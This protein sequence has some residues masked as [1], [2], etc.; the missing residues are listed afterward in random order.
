MSSCARSCTGICEG[1]VSVSQGL[2][3]NVIYQKRGG[4]KN[5]FCYSVRDETQ[6]KHL[7]FNRMENEAL[8]QACWKLY[9]GLSH[10]KTSR[11]ISIR[12]AMVTGGMGEELS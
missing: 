12:I 1:G 11:T 10:H 3:M 4:K 7:H 8:E 9:G 2:Q 5:T 6:L